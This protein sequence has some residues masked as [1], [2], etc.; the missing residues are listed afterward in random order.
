MS[1]EE[2][3]LALHNAA[4]R[5]I[6][7]SALQWSP[8]LALSAARG[9]AKLKARGCVLDHTGSGYGENVYYS[10]KYGSEQ[11]PRTPQEVMQA[12]MVEKKFYDPDSNTCDDGK[13]CGHYTQIVWENSTEVGCAKRLCITDE[14]EEVWV[15]QYDPGGNI[16]GLRPY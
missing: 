2:E 7:V 16:E 10:R 8:E 4:R 12:F 5:A 3:L 13:I 9:A 11:T 14:R 1:E 6:G 15:C